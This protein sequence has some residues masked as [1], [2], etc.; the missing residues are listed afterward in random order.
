MDACSRIPLSVALRLQN[1]KQALHMGE[2]QTHSSCMC[3]FYVYIW[4]KHFWT[5]LV[6]CKSHF[7]IVQKSTESSSFFLGKEQQKCPKSFKNHENSSF[8]TKTD[9]T[10][11]T[12][13]LWAGN[14]EFKSSLFCVR[15]HPADGWRQ[16]N[17]Y[18]ELWSP[19]LPI[20][21]VSSKTPTNTQ[22]KQ[23]V[24]TCGQGSRVRSL[25]R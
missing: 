12:R 2:A 22:Q 23:S 13:T 7:I 16:E 9:V 6:S 15:N 4:R 11:Q 10:S 19:E 21:Q 14:G 20:P 17:T 24:Q 8:W 1:L 25:P 3:L 18:Q 5:V